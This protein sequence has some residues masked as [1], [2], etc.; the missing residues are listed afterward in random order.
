MSEVPA[1]GCY[2][3]VN[4]G[5]SCSVDAG[6][7]VGCG[8]HAP[9]SLVPPARCVLGHP[10]DRPEVTHAGRVCRRHFGWLDSTLDQVE[11]LFGLA[12]LVLAPGRS[13]GPGEGSRGTTVHGH[14]PLHLGV[15][16]LTDRRNHATGGDNDVPDVSGVLLSWV[17]L[18]LEERGAAAPTTRPAP[19]IGPVCPR[20]EH[21]SCRIVR[22][23]T[24]VHGD[25]VFTPRTGWRIRDGVPALCA[26]LHRERHWTAGQEWVTDYAEEL[27]D[28][29]RAI[30]REVGDTMWPKSMGP[31]PS[32]QTPLHTTVGV[33]IVTCRRCKS[34][35]SGMHLVRLRLV[36]EQDQERRLRSRV[37][38]LNGR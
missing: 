22:S 32:C 23:P 17:T 9:R 33:D 3:H 18:I 27:A 12:P 6:F 16:A 36:L 34:S 8:P 20:C 19:M 1:C 24:V 5:A 7:G 28:L 30:A 31:C 25:W 21:T 14:A 2:C 13:S 38:G 11:E 35:W 10:E 26:V 37:D 15:A 4:A 29:H